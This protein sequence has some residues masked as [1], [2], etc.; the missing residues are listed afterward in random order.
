ME[1]SVADPSPDPTLADKRLFIARIAVPCQVFLLER[2]FEQAP[3]KA[4]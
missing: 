1:L 3:S 4:R 2:L